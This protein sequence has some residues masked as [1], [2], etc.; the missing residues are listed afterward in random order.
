MFGYSQS[1]KVLGIRDSVISENQILFGICIWSQKVC[2]A[3]CFCVYIKVENPGTN[4]MQSRDQF[5]DM[6]I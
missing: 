4:P 3:L 2:V 6:C 5:K 1:R